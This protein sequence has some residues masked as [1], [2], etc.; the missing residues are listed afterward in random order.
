MMKR[1]MLQLGMVAVSVLAA[2]GSAGAADL[3]VTTG[4]S[5]RQQAPVVVQSAPAPTVVQP[6]PP[7]VLV[8]TAPAQPS[9]VIAQPA[10]QIVALPPA[11]PQ[12]VTADS[13]KAREVRA[14]TIYG[15]VIKAL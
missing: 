12:T 9:S 15:N 7:S 10:P 14:Q 6:S 2:T 3:H 13:I 4:A 5:V 11:A 1:R 8:Q